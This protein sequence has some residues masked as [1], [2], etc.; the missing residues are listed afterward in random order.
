MEYLT[1]QW[2]TISDEDISEEIRKRLRKTCQLLTVH[3]V[4]RGF[5]DYMHLSPPP[6]K[7]KNQKDIVYQLFWVWLVY[8]IVWAERCRSYYI[9]KFSNP[10]IFT[11]C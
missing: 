9:L 10:Y 1:R 8:T 7:K 4:F 3:I 5:K 2:D 11:S 6:P